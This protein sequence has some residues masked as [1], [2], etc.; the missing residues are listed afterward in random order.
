MP[1]P[2]ERHD[3][4]HGPPWRA[5]WGGDRPPW[6]PEGERWPPEPGAWAGVRRRF[7]RRVLGAAIGALLV[8]A[9][10]LSLLVSLVWHASHRGPAFA[11]T[12]LLLLGAVALVRSVRRF[13][14]TLGE[15]MEAADRVAEGDTSARVPE[16]GTPDV[17]RLARSFNRMTERLRDAETRRRDLLA[18]V[19]HELRT[20][21]A[22]VRGTVEALVDGVYPADAAHLQPILDEAAVMARLLEDLQTVS[23]ADAG[24]LKL[25]RERVGPAELVDDVVATFRP[26]ADASGIRLTGAAAPGLPAVDVDRV[27][28]DEV[29]ANLLAN[30]MRH[31]PSGGS[32][33][34]SA[35][36]A[37]DGVDFSVADT[38]SGIPPEQLPH[39]FERFAKSPSSGGSGLGLAIARSLVVAHGGS[40]E[41]SS[42]SGRGATVR[43]TLPVAR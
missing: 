16:R 18:D 43:L 41:A 11:V 9:L 24:A 39:V 2:S 6:W 34:V 12:V 36:S 27:R 15:V 22:V 5:G 30:A 13:A 14:G 1:E 23:S 28:I 38:G 7:V 35:A 40:I 31:T 33:E 19:T 8:L 21:L 17:R 26:T 42:E 3:H 29:F 4:P 37:P 25:R 32:I 20:P 10:A